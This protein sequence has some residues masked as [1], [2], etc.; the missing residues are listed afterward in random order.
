MYET[1][2]GRSMICGKQKSLSPTSSIRRVFVIKLDN[3]LD[4]YAT[5]TLAGKEDGKA[6][7][8]FQS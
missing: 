8:S 3:F 4:K 1:D 7:C 5:K 6:S 2:T